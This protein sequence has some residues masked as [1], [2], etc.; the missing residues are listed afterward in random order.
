MAD[1]VDRLATALA[2]R[3][4]LGREIGA[5]GMATVYLAGDLKHDRQVAVKVL[6]PEVAASLGSARFIRE[7]SIAAKLNHPHILPLFDSGEAGGFLYYVMPFV[8]GESLRGRLDRERTL[9]VSD[10]VR[11]AEQVG[12]ALGY[13]HGHDVIHRDIK[14]ENILLVED[15]AIVA[16]FGIARA[17][18]VAGGDQLTGTGLAIGTPAYMSPEQA[19]G[20][21][22]V[23][24]RTDIYALGCMVY[25]MLAGRTPFEGATTMQLLSRHAAGTVPS[26]RT[27]DPAV[28]LHVERAVARALAKDPSD[29]FQKVNEF[30]GALASGTVV[31][32]V[33]RRRVAVLPPVDITNDPDQAYLVLGLHEAMISELGRGEIAVLARSSVLKYQGGG[34]VPRDIAREL[35]VE[36]VIESSLF[37][38]GT[39]VGI[40]A[41][42]IDG[43]SEEGLWSGSFDGEI[44]DILPLYR[45]FARS[46]SEGVHDALGAT[47]KP[48]RVERRTIAPAAYENYMRGRVHQ[49]GFTPRDFDIAMQYYQ[50]AVELVP[51]YAAA[52]SGIAL[53]W[54]SR[55]VL[56]LTPPLVGGPEWK[57]AAL[58]AV[59]LDPELAEARQALAQVYT[60]HDWDW[61][62][63]EEE[64]QNAV[65]L[66]PNDPQTR[67][68]YSHFLA[69]MKRA[70]ESSAQIARALEIDPM[71]PFHHTMHGMQLMLTGQYQEAVERF[72]RSTGMGQKN[73]LA[74]IGLATATYARGD[75]NEAV[76]HYRDYF[77]LLGD[78]QTAGALRASGN[79]G[80]LRAG[81]VRAAEILAERA[82]ER[83]VK[84]INISLL[85]DW[86]GDTD[87]AIEWLEKSYELKDHD[88]AYMAVVPRSKEVA[89]DPRYHEMLRRMNLPC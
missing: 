23:D 21:G 15:Q 2:G 27:R 42:L 69:M 47:A 81:L 18:E 56:G 65:A 88:M 53:I 45:R 44:G 1:T 80:T 30:S 77:T 82:R 67:T 9:P 89:S 20:S 35:A 54:G 60:W 87:R 85:F 48:G 33:G 62:L 26:L 28:P 72:E 37:R 36:A 86:G 59:E 24:G 84:P 51:G 78:N 12:S 8:E 16:D 55:V 14:P 13:A 11:I 10:A 29:R 3:Y 75:L 79:D 32:P 46:I 50:A 68:F 70:A 61:K 31:P 49:Q 40:Q 43:H 57:K 76:A 17:V 22:E 39:T 38:V 73:P 34:A 66:D 41:R 7:I 74:C 52:Y 5:G 19:F 71:N 58:R 4:T 83:F 25:E 6:R 64:F 63:A